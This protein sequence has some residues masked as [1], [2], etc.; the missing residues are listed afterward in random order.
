MTTVAAEKKTK[1]V[2]TIKID[3]DKCYGYRSF[4]VVCSA[5][6]AAPRD[7][8]NNPARF[9]I[10]IIRESLSEI[11]VPVY[12]GEYKPAVCACRVKY[13]IDCKE[14]EK[15]EFYYASCSSRE[16]IKGSDIRHPFKCDIFEGEDEPL[17]VK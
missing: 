7:S 14:Y 12:A 10:R 11:F 9:R 3:L 2:K 6:Q 5:F 15:C 8:S 13:T 4:E 17:C 1:I 16:E